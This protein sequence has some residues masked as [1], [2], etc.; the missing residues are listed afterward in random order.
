MEIIVIR[1]K[2][3]WGSGIRRASKILFCLFSLAQWY[4]PAFAQN[5]IKGKVVAAVDHSALG[6]ATIRNGY[7]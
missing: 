2:F 1:K 6:G 7:K 4:S 3:L 5:G